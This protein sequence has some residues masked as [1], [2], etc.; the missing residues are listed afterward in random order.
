[1]RLPR[2]EERREV[3]E[4]RFRFLRRPTQGFKREL[5]SHHYQHR[6]VCGPRAIEYALR[7]D[8]SASFTD[9]SDVPTVR[10]LLHAGR[11]NVVRNEPISHE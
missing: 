9:A 6:L 7:F 5:A 11:Q 1:M 4:P 10:G 8:D 3:D 2:I